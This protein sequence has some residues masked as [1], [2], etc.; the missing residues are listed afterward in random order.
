[1]FAD[2]AALAWRVWVARAYDT[3]PTP[4]VRH[5]RPAWADDDT[6]PLPLARL[7]FREVR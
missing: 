1:M 3:A 5:E 4:R 2:T 6:V 7:G